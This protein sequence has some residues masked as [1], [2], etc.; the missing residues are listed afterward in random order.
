MTGKLR[1]AL[2]LFAAVLALGIGLE[3]GG[4]PAVDFWLSRLA[5]A[6]RTQSGVWLA[7][8]TI[9]AGEIR[10]AV[11][12]L[13]AAFLWFRSRGR[14]AVL[15][16]VVALVQ[17]GTNSALK[18]LF[19]RVRPELYTHLDRTFDLSYPSGHA[20]QNAALYL[21]IALLI[22]R[23]LLWIAVPL[24]ILIGCSRV[25]LGVHWPTDVLGGWMEGVGFALLGAHLSQRLARRS[26]S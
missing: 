7:L 26:L 23:R 12:L 24:A 20:A 10:A 5:A 13:A 25:V 18:A 8:S 3:V 4:T 9:G 11:G 21:L 15:L 17:S 19:A 6:G 16:L 14:D 1:A 2:I 22:D